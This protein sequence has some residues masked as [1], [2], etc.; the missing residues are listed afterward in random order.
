MGVSCDEDYS[1]EKRWGGGSRMTVSVVN[2]GRFF[3]LA[4]SRCG[5]RDGG[6]G[7]LEWGFHV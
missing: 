6:G 3:L 4:N 2:Q 7:A 5:R 1:T